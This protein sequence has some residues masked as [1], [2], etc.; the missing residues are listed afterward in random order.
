M[1]NEEGIVVEIL[2]T[3][4]RMKVGKHTECKDC[5][6]CPGNDS[7]IIT[8]RNEIDAKVGQRV[9]FRVKDSSEVKG[10]FV[11]FVL[12]MTGIFIG[13]LLGNHIGKLANFN[14]DFGMVIGGL[15]GFLLSLL[16]VKRF[17]KA[18]GK[19]ERYLPVITKIIT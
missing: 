10:A 14:T 5:G 9:T 4:V 8:V 19:N 6:A 2:G 7:A 15:I 18:V 12:P 1:K 17:D 3:T 16:I 13:A 11:V